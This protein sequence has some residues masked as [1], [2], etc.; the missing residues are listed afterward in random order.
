MKAR[1]KRLLTSRWRELP[2]M[3]SVPDFEAS[4]KKPAFIR[5]ICAG[6]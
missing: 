4:Q 2:V 3:R 5:I 1:R 6:L